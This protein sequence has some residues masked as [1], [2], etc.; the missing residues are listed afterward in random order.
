MLIIHERK[1]N[2]YLFWGNFIKLKA[3]TCIFFSISFQQMPLNDTHWAFKKENIASLLPMMYPASYC[4]LRPKL[5]EPFNELI[6][7]VTNNEGT[8]DKGTNV[9][10]FS[11]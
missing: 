10:D 9:S 1:D 5:N 2:S 8:N 6:N 4:T 11:C 3:Y 7:T